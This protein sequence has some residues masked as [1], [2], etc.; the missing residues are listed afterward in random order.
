MIF[1]KLP[2]V[3]IQRLA[4]LKRLPCENSEKS[5]K[6]LK[7]RINQ[8]ARVKEGQ[9]DPKLAGAILEL[10]Q[11]G[12][13]VSI[14]ILII[15]PGAVRVLRNIAGLHLDFAKAQHSGHMGARYLLLTNWIED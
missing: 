15:G 1:P 12:L 3:K 14:T 7:S 5:I 11:G 8:K 2:I 6:S 13:L 9:A 4:A 10:A